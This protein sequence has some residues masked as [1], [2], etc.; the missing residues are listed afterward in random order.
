MKLRIKHHTVML[1]DFHQAWKH[2]GIWRLYKCVPK[3]GKQGKEAFAHTKKGLTALIFIAIGCSQ[4]A[5]AQSSLPN[6]GDG[7]EMTASAERRLGDRIARELYRD[8]DFIDDPVLVDYVQAIWQRLMSAARLRGELSP[9]IEERFAWALTLGRDRS[10]NAFAL[11]G[12][13]L[14]VHLGLLAV[15]SSPDELASVLAHEL[16]HVTQRHISRLISRQGATT[17]WLIGAMLLGALAARGNPNVANAMITGG[18][19]V[20]VQGQLNF[21]RDMEREADRVGYGILVQAGFEPQGFVS[22]FEKLQK[23]SRLNDSGGFPYLRSHPVTTE[24]IADMQGRQQLLPPS[25]SKETVSLQHAM[26]SARARALTRPGIDI[27]RSWVDQAVAASSS[28]PGASDPAAQAGLLYQGVLAASFQRD[29]EQARRLHKHLQT[30]TEGDT[31]AAELVRLLGAELALAGG[32]VRGAVSVMS[33]ADEKIGSQSRPAL[34][35]WAQAM[36][37]SGQGLEVAQRL[38]TWLATRPQ[39]AQAWQLLAAAYQTQNKVQ[40]AIRAEAESFASLLD[41]PSAVNRMKVAQQMSRQNANGVNA[42]HIEASIID[43]RTRELELLQREQALE[44]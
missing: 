1:R 21:S 5:L 23:A 24:R 41:Y 17:P 16:S 12:G 34:F 29:F 36:T 30:L 13:Y 3:S 37:R 14:G 26:I 10:V 31:A 27:L 32:D 8:P 35:L 42:D 38:Q 18:Q 19:A 15:V 25:K 44:R 20:A 7:L 40:S 28:P 39:D 6:L 22:M 2:G 43:A 4:A 33:K 11:P 9:E